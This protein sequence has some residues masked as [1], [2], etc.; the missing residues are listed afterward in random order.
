MLRDY[1]AHRRFEYYIV[2]VEEVAEYY[3]CEVYELD[4]L[5]KDQRAIHL[6]H[7]DRKLI[8]V[9]SGYHVH[10]KRF[11]IGHEL[12]HSI[13]RHPAESDCDEDEI[14]EYNREAD[15]FAADLLMPR[16]MVKEALN[17]HHNLNSLSRAFLVSTQAM[18]I[19]LQ[20]FNLLAKLSV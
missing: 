7:E 8:G 5:G 12:G 4:N 17:Q 16:H 11:S 18:T 19:Q 15:E 20:K 13:L 3:G 2:P 1:E 9:N 10:N 6:V 14:K